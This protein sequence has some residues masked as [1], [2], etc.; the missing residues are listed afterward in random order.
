VASRFLLAL[1]GR[2]ACS[3][4]RTAPKAPGRVQL[5]D[6][7]DTLIEVPGYAQQG[8][9]LGYTRVRGNNA[10]LATLSSGHAHPVEGRR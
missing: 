2:P 10:L 4:L 5:V 1:V 9:G 7:D 8:A 6:V 3:P